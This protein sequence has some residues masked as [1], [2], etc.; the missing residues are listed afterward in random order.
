M[1]LVVAIL[2]RCSLS[3]PFSFF[4]TGEGKQVF[5][6]NTRERCGEDGIEKGLHTSGATKQ[7]GR[8]R[9]TLWVYEIKPDWMAAN[10][11]RA[12][13]LSIFLPIVLAEKLSP[14]RTIGPAN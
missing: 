7:L 6:N 5:Y 9:S 14:S 3:L 4:L 11:L 2:P 12:V 8:D 13:P 1:M 10:L